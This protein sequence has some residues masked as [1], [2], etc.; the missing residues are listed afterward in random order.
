VNANLSDAQ[1]ELLRWHQKLGHVSYQRVQ[2]LMRSGVL[3]H[4]ESMRRLH[5]A[6][7]KLRADGCPL[8]G[9]CQ[10]GKQRRRPTP[11]RATTAVQETAGALQRDDLHPGQRNSVDHFICSTRGRLLN[12]RGKESEQEKYAGG[13]IF[14]DH[15]SS[16]IHVKMQAL[17]TSA[18]TIK[19]KQ[20]FEQLCRDYGVVPHSYQSDN[21]SAFTSAAF[22]Q[23]LSEQQQEIRYAGAGAQHHK[24]I[25]ERAIQS[26]MSRVRT[27][28][29]HAT[30][31]WP[32]A[33]TT[34]L[35]PFAV[36]H[37]VHLHNFVPD[38]STGLSP[39]DLFTKT[40]HPSKRF[41]DLHPLFC[42]SYAL[43]K[44]IADGHKLPRWTP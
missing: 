32:D 41:Y 10:L 11:G 42:P 31:H 2:F 25:A 3:C 12:T 15:A 23:H 27:M 43:D 29:L 17:V 33:V 19:A 40:K 28:L 39:N 9:A 38:P 36:R 20:K 14:V 37:A 13:C 34:Q 8:C 4:T 6:S 7:A 18:K 1:R 22:A 21:G 35:W 24:G 30:L 26:I 16:F 44:A 5:A